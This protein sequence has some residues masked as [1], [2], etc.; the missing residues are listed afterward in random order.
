MYSCTFIFAKRNSQST[1]ALLFY[2][3]YASEF[4][5]QLIPRNGICGLAIKAPS[6]NDTEYQLSY[7]FFFN[8]VMSKPRV[9]DI[10]YLKRYV[11]MSHDYKDK[12]WSFEARMPVAGTYRI[13][14]YGGPSHRAILPWICDV[15]VYCVEPETNVRPYPDSPLIGFGPVTMTEKAGLTEPSHTNGALF[16]RPR[17]VFHITFKLK[18]TIE[19][20]ADLVGSKVQEKQLG[21]WVTCTVNN[22]STVHVL[23]VMVK[24][25]EEG[26]YAL[27]IYTRPKNSNNKW[28]NVCNYYLSTDPPRELGVTLSDK[29]YKVR[30]F[31]YFI[32]LHL[33]LVLSNTDISKYPIVMILNI[34][35]DMS[36][37]NSADPDQTAPHGA[38]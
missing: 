29:G 5:S 7:D 20:K 6:D 34:G 1:C 15:G 4:K 8:H 37:Q 10:I 19:A 14:V 13:T 9:D 2:S 25:L 26:E 23:D 11:L 33:T 16:V 24:L 21:K 3:R 28:L 36:E 31:D 17:K 35:T 32:C 18:R 12:R 38:V 22:P 27:K 30:C